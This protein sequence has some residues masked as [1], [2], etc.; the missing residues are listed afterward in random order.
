MPLPHPRAIQIDIETR[1]AARRD[2]LEWVR[3]LPGQRRNDRLAVAI[4]HSIRVLEDHLRIA[5]KAETFGRWPV[6]AEKSLSQYLTQPR[7]PAGQSNGGQWVSGGGGEASTPKR[8]KPIQVAN[9]GL[10]R[11][12]FAIGSLA[13]RSILPG[14]L[15]DNVIQFRVSND[16]VDYFNRL[17]DV[18]TDPQTIP[19]IQY[20]RSWVHEQEGSGDFAYSAG[21]TSREE[22]EK[23][24]KYY[25]IMQA[26]ADKVDAMLDQ[27]QFSSP[28]ERGT[29][30]HTLAKQELDQMR[31]PGLKTEISFVGNRSADYGDEGSVRVDAVETIF[32]PSG[33]RTFCI[34]DFKSGRSDMA[35][36]RANVLINTQTF[37]IN[38]GD[39]IFLNTV[40]PTRLY[41]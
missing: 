7:A 6:Y 8:E 27:K 25:G 10:V 4:N 40:H 1:L 12:A 5:Q 31:L 18:N 20:E 35:G 24:C 22:V 36:K 3:G 13:A 21:T 17:T 30:F 28:A 33:K 16:A 34:T 14:V 15:A 39:R 41:R 9:A 2:W 37:E 29:A 23:S 11:G 26:T 32:H 19:F 38:P